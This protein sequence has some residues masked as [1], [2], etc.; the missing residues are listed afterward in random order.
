MQ[1]GY[2][3]VVS[4]A[5]E[6]AIRWP[7]IAALAEPPRRQ[8]LLRD[9]ELEPPQGQLELPHGL[10][11]TPSCLGLSLPDFRKQLKAVLQTIG[12][13]QVEKMLQELMEEQKQEGRVR[14]CRRAVKGPRGRAGSGTEM[15]T[16][17]M[18][19]WDG[20]AVTAGAWGIFSGV[21]AGSVPQSS[22]QDAAQACQQGPDGAPESPSTG[23]PST[24]ACGEAIRTARDIPAPLKP[25][26]EEPDQGPRSG[27]EED[28]SGQGDA[29]PKAGGALEEM[30]HGC[31]DGEE[32]S[33]SPRTPLLGVEA[34]RCLL[35]W[36][37]L[38]LQPWPVGSPCKCLASGRCTG[39][40]SPVLPQ[41][42][43]PCECPAHRRRVRLGTGLAR[44]QRTPV[45][46]KGIRPQGSR[47]AC[48]RRGSRRSC[49]AEVPVGWTSSP[50]AVVSPLP[51]G[52][53]QC[54]LCAECGKGFTQRSALSKHRRIHSGERPH[55]CGDCGKRFLQRSDLTI[56]QRRH[57]GERPYGCPECGRRF[58]VSSNLAKH[59]RAHLGQRPFPCPSCGKAFTQRSELVIHQ[60]L[61][62]G[63]R[64]YCCPLCAKCFSR[65][66]HLTRH[67]RTH[68]PRPPAAP[69]P[70]RGHSLELGGTARDLARSLSPLPRVVPQPLEP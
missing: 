40:V 28:C 33:A 6:I 38:A 67:Q 59:R 60:R 26:S 4:Q 18:R 13:S 48:R 36:A 27:C 8:S 34:A 58:S 31:A 14:R 3:S 21:T 51:A 69:H 43:T 64:P 32:L 66:S 53:R 37:E 57:T 5:E 35:P 20:N 41:H 25:R 16:E 54:Y 46:T 22:E 2:E 65:R 47:V 50:V 55:Q 62:T 63:E 17:E 70:D 11:T 30:L 15:V 44:H 24:S 9:A 61:H 42:R 49:P 19:P 7:R 29:P 1:D 52:S 12:R 23:P 68:G 45:T 56:H 10:A 39:P